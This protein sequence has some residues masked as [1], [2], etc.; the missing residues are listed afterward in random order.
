MAVEQ[1]HRR[2][3]QGRHCRKPAAARLRQ[4]CG[5]WAGR[6]GCP[7]GGAN[8]ARE[9]GAQSLLR[10]TIELGRRVQVGQAH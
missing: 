4:C 3:E 6:S 1:G 5:P 7:G 8:E 2:Q 10:H 9:T